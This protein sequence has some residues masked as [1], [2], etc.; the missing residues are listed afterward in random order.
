MGDKRP[1][2]ASTG[3]RGE[4][5]IAWRRAALRLAAVLLPFLALSLQTVPALAA[6]GAAWRNSATGGDSGMIANASS[7][8]KATVFLSGAELT[9]TMDVDLKTGKNTI[10]FVG[11]P[12]DVRPESVVASVEGKAQLMSAVFRVNHLESP[13]GAE[14]VRKLN[15]ELRAVE[16]TISRNAARLPVLDAEADFLNQNRSIAGREG[17][18]LDDLRAVAEYYR[19]RLEAVAGEKLNIRYEQEELQKKLDR[20]AQQ[21]GGDIDDGRRAVGEI[22]VELS[23]EAPGQARVEVSYF[24]HAAGWVP[25]YEIR[26]AEAE[27][28]VRLVGKGRVAQTTGEDWRDVEV[29]LSSGTP[30]IGGMQPTLLP[31]YV[32][33]DTPKADNRYRMF[34]TMSA[35]GATGDMM[36]MQEAAVAPPMSSSKAAPKPIAQQ[37]Q[38]SVEFLLPAPIDVPSQEEAQVVEIMN[39]ELPATYQHYSVRKLDRDVFLL[40]K[41]DGWEKLSLLAGETGIFLGNTYVGTTY[42]D[43]RRAED[44]L[45]VS[46]GRDSGVTVTRVKGRDFASRSLLGQND[47]VTREWLIT[48]RNTRKTPIDIKVLDQIPVSINKSITVEAVEV[49]GA[50]HDSSTGE[51]SWELTLQPG[52]SAQKTVKYMVTYPHGSNVSL[53]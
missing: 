40:A 32:D 31:W 9:R 12:A 37:A 14:R 53:E 30:A 18:K 25:F 43:P 10:A 38:T 46:L 7:V 44:T 5:Y 52:E 27:G 24:V 50:K 26:A 49:S 2:H 45:E 1:K 17:I 16:E 23:A 22:L 19:S 11:L 3:F 33:F 51:L 34:N 39:E 48:V 36:V 6:D 42:I 15:E 35:P 28:P 8:H 47:K 41:I 21:L 4:R 29:I 20:L 13:E